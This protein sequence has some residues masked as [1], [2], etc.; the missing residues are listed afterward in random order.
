MLKFFLVFT[1]VSNC[2]VA[3]RPV[4]DSDSAAI[5]KK[6]FNY[7]NKL[8]DQKIVSSDEFWAQ[9]QLD[10]ASESGDLSEKT[11]EPSLDDSSN[12]ELVKDVVEEGSEVAKGSEKVDLLEEIKKLRHEISLLSKTKLETTTKSTSP[13]E[14]LAGL[15]PQDGK[16]ASGVWA[17]LTNFVNFLNN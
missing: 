2:F 12:H 6:S 13:L 8:K 16:E 4:R 3:S 5:G 17:T 14:I 11:L 15:R 9:L 10:N 7:A 1:L